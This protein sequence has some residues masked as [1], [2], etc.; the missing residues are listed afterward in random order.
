MPS[1]SQLLLTLEF[2]KLAEKKILTTA[3][4]PS[5]DL[6]QQTCKQAKF[7]LA[8]ITKTYKNAKLWPPYPSSLYPETKAKF[9]I[10][11]IKCNSDYANKEKD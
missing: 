5:Y 4:P 2:S 3:Y 9:K 1:L 8:I 11:C 6:T 10:F 7:N